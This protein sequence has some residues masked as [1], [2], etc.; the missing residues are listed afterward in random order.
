MLHI[1]AIP[2][3]SDN[4]FWLLTQQ[5]LNENQPQQA[6]IIDPGD[7][8]A[9]D[10]ILTQYQLT[11]T[12]ILITHR[13]SDHTGGINFLTHRYQAP[14]SST[15]PVYG[16]DSAS[17]PQI[18]H[19]LY[20]ND[21][22]TLFEYYSLNVMETPGHTPEH[23]VYYSEHMQEVPVL[24]CGDTLFAG[25][26]GRL[27]GGT[28]EQLHHSLQRLA[29]L[30]DNTRVYCAHEYTLANLTFAQ[31]VEP[32]NLAIQQRLAAVRAA[33]ADNQ[34]TIPFTLSAEYQ[35]NPFLRAHIDSVKDVIGDYSQTTAC[36]SAPSATE[37]FTSLRQWK[38]QFKEAVE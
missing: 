24:F 22:V 12:G 8:E 37:V 28:A 23:I 31:A 18:T 15:I 16:P 19:K 20:E 1:T 2:A 21:T 30:P 5:P 25:G 14:T 7:G 3:F 35:T 17:I 38:D 4:Y 11:L 9:V 27:L 34:S 32:K 13:H 6:Y 36:G 10:R 33:R 26:C 29:T